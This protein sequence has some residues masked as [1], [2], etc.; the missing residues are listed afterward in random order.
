MAGT[1]AIK[2]GQL[3]KTEEGTRRKISL[4]KLET[5]GRE[6]RRGSVIGWECAFPQRGHPYLVQLH[7]GAILRTSPVQEIRKGREILIIKTMNSVYQ[8]EY[9]DN[10]S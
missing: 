8:V 2:Q 4:T 9:L 5:V 10:S 7:R 3:A 6:P 1:I